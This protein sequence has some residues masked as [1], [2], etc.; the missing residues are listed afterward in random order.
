M[1]VDV[2][3]FNKWRNTLQHPIFSSSWL[4]RHLLSHQKF[5]TLLLWALPFTLTMAKYRF[6]SISKVSKHIKSYF[7][8]NSDTIL[9]WENWEKLQKSSVWRNWR[10]SIY[11]YH[12]EWLTVFHLGLNYFSFKYIRKLWFIAELATEIL[13][14]VMIMPVTIKCA[15]WALML[16]LHFLYYFFKVSCP[17]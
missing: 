16:S 9:L 13:S 17:N 12:S 14:S 5:F 7:I 4:N 1:V 2:S 15:I 8:S 10:V 11:S 3:F 6:L